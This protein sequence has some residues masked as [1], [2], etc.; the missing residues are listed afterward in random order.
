MKLTKWGRHG[1]FVAQLA[2][3][4]TQSQWS[5]ETFARV[6]RSQTFMVLVNQSE[7]S[8][9][10]VYFEFLVDKIL[11]YLPTSTAAT[12]SRIAVTWVSMR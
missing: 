6:Q 10:F 4:R 3:A 8:Q 9:F 1:L 2:K 11:I 12:V 7:I 5:F